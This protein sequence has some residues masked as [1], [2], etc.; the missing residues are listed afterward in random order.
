MKILIYLMLIQFGVSAEPSA[1]IYQ[2]VLRPFSSDGCSAFFDSNR[3]GSWQH[4]CVQHDLHYWKGG[5]K[6]MRKNA[7]KQLRDCV[8]DQE[9]ALG[10]L[11]YLGVRLGGGS[12]LPFTWRW[13]YGWYVPRSYLPTTIEEQDYINFM[14][15]SSIETVEIQRQSL[16]GKRDTVTENYCLDLALQRLS[17]QE[18][19]FSFEY[20][21]LEEKMNSEDTGWSQHYKIRMNEIN[22]DYL[23][24]LIVLNRSA[25]ELNS[26]REDPRR[27][28]QSL[29][30]LIK[31]HKI[32][33]LN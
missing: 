33:E 5:T 21:V 2:N 7:D 6:Q 23:V 22:K 15:P 32:K 29:R 18:G 24:E 9:P 27:G 19:L 17:E 16:V 12:Y 20:E 26:R 30:S 28:E 10:G 3:G 11:V 25:C 14:Q 4:C 13:G 8:N 1:E 31:V